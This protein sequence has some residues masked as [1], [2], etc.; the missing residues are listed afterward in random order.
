L[1][2]PT[3]VGEL[4][5]RVLEIGRTAVARLCYRCQERDEAGNG[6]CTVCAGRVA[7][8]QRSDR[9]AE[10]GIPRRYAGASPADIDAVTWNRVLGWIRAEGW[11]LVLL[12]PTGC[13]KSHLAAAVLAQLAE[14]PGGMTWM[15]VPALIDRFKDFDHSADLME[16]LVRVPTLVL[17]DLAAERLTDFG[18]DRVATLVQARYDGCRRTIVTTNLDTAALAELHGRMA[19]RLLGTGDGST[20]IKLGGSDRRVRKAKT[21]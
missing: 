20:V 16:R 1:V 17:D 15:S 9:L 18:L 7:A 19:S 4:G 5:S 10:A 13:G 3:Q 6:L 2:K 14:G 11:A 21:A 8:E 12:G